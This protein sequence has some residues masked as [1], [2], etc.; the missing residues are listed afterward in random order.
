MGREPGW[1][2]HQLGRDPV[3]VAKQL[4]LQAVSEERDMQDAKWGEQD[5][6]DGTGEGATAYLRD[7]ARQYCQVTAPLTAR[8]P[9]TTSSPRSMLRRWP[10]RIQ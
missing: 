6:P 3:T 7:R 9:G 1:A 10:R 5:H 2:V 8:S 4:V